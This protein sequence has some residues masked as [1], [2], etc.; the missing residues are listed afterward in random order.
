MLFGTPYYRGCGF[1]NI[2]R[3]V[4]QPDLCLNFPLSFWLESGFRLVCVCDY[5]D[6]Q[7][8]TSVDLEINAP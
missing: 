2:A 1:V 8:D 5:E 7:V 3:A 6:V 4:T